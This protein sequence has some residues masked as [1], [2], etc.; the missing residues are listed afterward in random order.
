LLFLRKNKLFP[1]TCDKFSILST[2]ENE[3]DKNAPANVKSTLVKLDTKDAHK[4]DLE[5]S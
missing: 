5:V 2:F 4:I 1:N 3:I